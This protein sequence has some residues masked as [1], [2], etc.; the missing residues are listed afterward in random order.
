MGSCS[1]AVSKAK[2]YQ[3]T[4]NEQVKLQISSEKNIRPRGMSEASTGL[5]SK[6]Y[7]PFSKNGTMEPESPQ[8]PKDPETVACVFRDNGIVYL[9]PNLKDPSASSIL[10]R[11]QRFNLTPLFSNNNIV[12]VQPRTRRFASESY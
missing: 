9:V 4:I 5:D 10:Q 8:F 12:T 1:S 11:R 2:A 6:S 7:T 3:R